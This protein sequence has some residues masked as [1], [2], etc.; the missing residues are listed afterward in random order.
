MT[1]DK[2]SIYE[3]KRETI[4]EK[5]EI[6]RHEREN[7]RKRVRWREIE[8]ERER[9]RERGREGERGGN[10]TINLRNKAIQ[11]SKDIQ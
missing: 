8:V 11:C 1:L 7:E 4:R 3:K 9:E 6:R 5:R 2:M 10:E